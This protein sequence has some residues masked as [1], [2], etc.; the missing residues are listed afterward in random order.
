MTDIIDYAHGISAIDAQFQRPRLNAIHL[1]VEGNRAAI[2]D[3]ASNHSVPLVLDALH[4]KGL[5]PENLDYIILTHIHLDHAGGAG[6]LM[7]HCPNAKLTVHPRG[8]RHIA[9]PT[10]LMEGTIAVYGQALAKRLYGEIVPVPKDRIIET[11]HGAGI[12]LNG[13][14]LRFLETSG[15]ARHCVCIHDSRSEHIFAGDTFGLSY[16]ELDCG[17]RQFVFP[18]TSP[19][20]FDPDALQLSIEA[21]LDLQPSAIYVTHYGQ[22]R[23]VARLGSDLKRLIEAHVQLAR[24][25]RNA[26]SSRH[27]RL[28]EGVARLVVEEAN[29]SCW[30]L[31]GDDALKVFAGDIELNAQGLG[32][33][34]DSL[35]SLA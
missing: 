1:I 16:R 33:W 22:V 14:E 29:R 25:E 32:A 8:A 31:R 7:T 17:E 12:S 10:K 27:E 19:V 9:D 15:H 34:L 21:L 24:R 20:Q 2:V 11:R 18:T 13:R 4:G 35:P 26:G 6:L 23:D 30:R 3:T 5:G 28:R